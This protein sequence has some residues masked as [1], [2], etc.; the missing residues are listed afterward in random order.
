MPG[1]EIVLQGYFL[2]PRDQEINA[3]ERLELSP[4]LLG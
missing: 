2:E 4:R 3:L 1:H